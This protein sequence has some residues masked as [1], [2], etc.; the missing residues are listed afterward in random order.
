MSSALHRYVLS[1]LC[2]DGL[3]PLLQASTQTRALVL[4]SLRNLHELVLPLNPRDHSN[5]MRAVSRESR[6]LRRVD[7]ARADCADEV[8]FNRCDRWLAKLIASN[9]YHFE[10]LLSS[11]TP[12]PLALRALL[13]CPLLTAL[14]SYL[15]VDFPD[16]SSF[17]KLR[18]FS[19][20][21]MFTA[22][23]V[24]MLARVAP[25]LARLDIRFDFDDLSGWRMDVILLIRALQPLPELTELNLCVQLSEDDDYAAVDE[26]TISTAVLPALTAFTFTVANYRGYDNRPTRAL[27]SALRTPALRRLRTDSLDVAT[28]DFCNTNSSITTLDLRFQAL[29]QP[30]ATA[31]LRHVEQLKLALDNDEWTQLQQQW[32]CAPVLTPQLRLVSLDVRRCGRNQPYG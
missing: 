3:S 19:C 14:H 26:P 32:F 7:A 25:H 17:A 23:R 30:P 5:V 22:L 15:A 16:S 20:A 1:F 18:E 9:Q 24:P 27:L 4:G 6:Q 21:E 8:C 10:Q 31:V 2:F 13:R 12:G 28:T 11:K 29:L